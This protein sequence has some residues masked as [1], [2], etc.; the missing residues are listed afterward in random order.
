LSIKLNALNLIP[1]KV[2]AFILLLCYIFIREG[3]TIMAEKL[4]TRRGIG[5]MQDNTCQDGE[6]VSR[7]LHLNL[8]IR[9]LGSNGKPKTQ[10][11]MEDRITQYFELCE[12]AQLNPTV[13]GLAMAV[14]YDRRSLFEISKGTFNLPFMDIVKKAKDF[15]AN[16]DAILAASNKMNSAVYCFRSKNFYGMKDN[17]QIEAIS[18]QS[19]DVPNQSGVDLQELP[20]APTIEIDAGKVVEEELKKREAIELAQN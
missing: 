16:Y 12:Q 13:E 6:F 4:V 10:Q 20:E 9:K 11:D 3:A 5:A 8:Q 18:N 14:D 15:I 1:N 17:I 2:V 19:G 7:A